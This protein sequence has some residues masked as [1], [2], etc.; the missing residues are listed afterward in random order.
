MRQAERLQLKREPLGSHV[1]MTRK[2]LHG[3]AHNMCQ[4]FLGYQIW[5]DLSQLETLGAGRLQLELLSG[6]CA[7]DEHLIEP[8]AIVQK[9][10]DWLEVQLVS[11]G[12]KLSDIEEAFLAVDYTVREG[13]SHW[14]GRGWHRT[15]DFYFRCRSTIR[16]FGRDYSSTAEGEKQFA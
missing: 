2:V 5:A 9:L 1:Y 14:W 8:L 13:A 6:R 10:R 3:L 7:K 12:L 16:A 11:N 4:I 15:W